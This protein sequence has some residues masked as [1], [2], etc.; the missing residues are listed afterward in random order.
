MRGINDTGETANFVETEQIV[1][2][3]DIR[4]AVTVIRGSVPC[5]W[6]QQGLSAELVFSR[7]IEMDEVAF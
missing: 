5:F 3:K 7:T 6:T 4:T 2:Y 1:S